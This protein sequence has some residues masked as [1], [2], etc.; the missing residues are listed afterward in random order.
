MPYFP[1][2]LKKVSLTFIDNNGATRGRGIGHNE[3][4][5]IA[6][7]VKNMRSCLIK[8]HSIFSKAF[9]KSILRIIWAY[10]PFF[11]E[12]ELTSS[13][14]M[15][16]LSATLLFWRKVIWI[17]L[18]MGWRRGLILL[19]IILEIILYWVLERI[20]G[21]KFL[22]KLHYC[23]LGWDRYRFCLPCPPFEK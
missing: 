8:F 6:W 5:D 23:I 1:G 18:I 13:W 16:A 3:F 12:R 22:W 9:S 2:W 17:W 20:I 19:A 7:E 21:L 11:L 10:P 14:T 4:N 15:I